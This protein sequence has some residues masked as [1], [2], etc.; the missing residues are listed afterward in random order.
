MSP[1]S[2]GQDG[3]TV[4]LPAVCGVC[5]TIF[6][7]GFVISGGRNYFSGNTAGPCPGCGGIGRIPD[8]LIDLSRSD[9]VAALRAMGALGNIDN[10]RRMVG[11]LSAASMD[12]LIAIRQ[13]LT[14]DT[15]GRSEDQVVQD[16]QRAA[17]RLASVPGLI[18]NR[19][20]R[21]ELVT[22]LMLLTA[23]IAIVIA[24]KSNHQEVT[25]SRQEQ[26]IQVIVPSPSAS[27]TARV[28]AGHH[29]PGRNERC[30]CGSG[31][32]FKHCHGSPTSRS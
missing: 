15:A 9:V 27:P 4:N 29:S 2:P 3:Q 18:R 17:P 1:S 8:G 21:M 7:S 5:G 22:W 14:V 32:K 30:P 31:K 16:V 19:D 24:V 10:L 11:L 26:I 20:S 6:P 13:A 12:E 23:I 28:Q 25:P